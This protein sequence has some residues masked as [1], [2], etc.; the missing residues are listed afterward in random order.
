MTKITPEFLDD[1]LKRLPELPDGPR[2]HAKSLLE[3]H[4]RYT[5]SSATSSA[6]DSAVV[7]DIFPFAETNEKRQQAAAMLDARIREIIASGITRSKLI[8][9]KL[10]EDGYQITSYTL[11]RITMA[12]KLKG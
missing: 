9:K 12:R 10:E 2:L 7:K 8:E 1:L 4:G 5:A 6:E 3:K 11:K